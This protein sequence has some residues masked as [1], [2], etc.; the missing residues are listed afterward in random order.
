MKNDG[1]RN[2]LH[3]IVQSVAITPLFW[4]YILYNFLAILISNG[5]LFLQ[6]LAAGKRKARK[7]QLQ[8]I[9]GNMIETEGVIREY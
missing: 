9:C 3:K 6:R 1:C 8:I 4:V 5:T 2:S 7:I